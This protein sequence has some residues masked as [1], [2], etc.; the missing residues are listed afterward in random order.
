MCVCEDGGVS[1]VM[2]VCVCVCVCVCAQE[3]GRSVFE[4][5]CMYGECASVS[6][7]FCQSVTV[8]V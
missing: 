7:Y 3:H 1:G 6:G 2:C 8:F 5:M 4:S